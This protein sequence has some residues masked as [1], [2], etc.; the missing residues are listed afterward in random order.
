MAQAPNPSETS[1][2][3]TPPAGTGG[4]RPRA[5]SQ[6][7][8]ERLLAAAKAAFAEVSTDVAL[9]EVARRAGVGIGTLYRHFPNRDAVVEAV[10]R[11]E[12]QQLADAAARLAAEAPPFEALQGWLNVFVDY[13]ATKKLMAQAL[14]PVV[15]AKPEVYA[16]AGPVITVAVTGLLER[17][18]TAGAIRGDITPDDLIRALIGFTYG[19]E[20]PGW[21]ASA[22]RLIDI[23]LQGLRAPATARD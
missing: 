17:A 8:R 11:R 12:V 20:G 16:A 5:D 3:G 6:R 13:I 15:G 14:A 21:K 18:R 22:L 7:N 4:R 2:T 19:S 1:P 9:E 10:Y 23:F